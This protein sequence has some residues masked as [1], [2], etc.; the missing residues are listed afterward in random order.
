MAY[1]QQCVH[2]QLTSQSWEGR[3]GT[4]WQFDLNGSLLQLE[5]ERQQF[6]IGQWKV[7]QSEAGLMLEI[8]L[9]DGQVYRCWANDCNWTRLHL[10]TDSSQALEISAL[11]AKTTYQEELIGEWQE[12]VH[13]TNSTFTF[14]ADG[15]YQKRLGSTDG[16]TTVASGHWVISHDGSTLLLYRH[17][18]QV[19]AYE[20]KY[21]KFDELVLRAYH[22]GASD[23]YL[24]KL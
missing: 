8:D 1:T 16:D 19:E 17:E 7:A 10:T 22:P 13:V 9:G 18:G 20:L 4:V 11:P 21:L 15:S 5:P 6:L 3:P 24:N 2:E 23:C 14:A 12:G